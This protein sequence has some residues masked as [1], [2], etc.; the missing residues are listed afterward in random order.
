LKIPKIYPQYKYSNEII[1]IYN[2]LDISLLD[3]TYD[4]YQHNNN[5]LYLLFDYLIYI[6]N[7][8]KNNINN[9]NSIIPINIITN[10]YQL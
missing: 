8:I 1:D 5:R 4:L 10:K 7:Q 6:N 2:N 9:I 3:F